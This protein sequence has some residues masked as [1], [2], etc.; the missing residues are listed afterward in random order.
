MHNYTHKKR[1]YQ[2][3]MIITIY[4][5]GGSNSKKSPYAKNITVYHITNRSALY[6]HYS[7]IPYYLLVSNLIGIISQGNEYRTSFQEFCES[8]CI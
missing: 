1:Q 3:R 2:T 5:N 8:I 7:R 6:S 4:P